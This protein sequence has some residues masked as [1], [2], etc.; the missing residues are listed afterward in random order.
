MW[1]LL[2]QLMR[3]IKAVGINRSNLCSFSVCLLRK[4]M[5]MSKI[6]MS[7]TG[8]DNRRN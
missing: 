6:L 4:P 5:W 2:F 8:S 1:G 7:N 3:L